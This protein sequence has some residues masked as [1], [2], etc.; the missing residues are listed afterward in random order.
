MSGKRTGPT[1]LVTPP[2]TPN[3]PLHV[4]HLSGPYVAGDIAARTARAVGRPVLTVCGL[5]SHQNY[6]LARAEALGQPP[7]R[8]IEYYGSLVRRALAAA[9]IPYDLFLDPTADA[10]Y[11]DGV[12]ALLGEAVDHK[13]VV[14]EDAAL[15]ACGGCGRTLHHVRVG[16]TCPACGNAAGGGT[17]EGCGSFLTAADLL[18]ATSSCCDAPPVPVIARIPVLRLNDHRDRLRETWTSAAL[19]PRVRTLVDRCLA[20]GLPDVPLAYPTDWGI[21]WS[22]PSVDGSAPLRIDVWAEMGFGYLYAVARH[23][24]PSARTTAEC[25]AAWSEV[26]GLWHFLGLDNAFYYSTMIP[27]L[28]LGAG[29]RPD[30]LSG[31][32]VNEFY[33]LDGAKF[34]TSRNHAIW[35][36]EFLAGEDPGTV[37]AY[38]S[39]DRPDHAGTDFTVA[40]YTAFRAWYGRVLAGG[41]GGAPDELADLE[42]ARAGQALQLSTF[43]PALAVRCLLAAY[44]R[45]PDAARDLLGRITGEPAAGRG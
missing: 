24:D 14:V 32:V 28:L 35:A 20:A 25:A 34:S 42:L 29:V 5:D 37:R 22:H 2:P 33:R 40:R 12:A 7:G 6:V 16:G 1:L 39:Y 27:A 8:T 41:T 17:C 21:P 45:R 31:L 23:L 18:D 13:A 3:G 11:R 30:V 15:S 38:L 4:G 9:R 26:A 36:H 44:P 43:D 10:D 19:P